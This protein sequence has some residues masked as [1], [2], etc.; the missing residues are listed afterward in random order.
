M[1]NLKE[2]F[3]ENLSLKKL[4]VF[5]IFEFILGAGILYFNY[6]FPLV[7][8]DMTFSMMAGAKLPAILRSALNQGN[9]RLLG[10]FLGYLVSFRLFTIIEKTFVWMGI[11][12][13]F[14]F[15]AGSKNLLFNSLTAII[16]IYPCD[17]IFSQVYAWNSGFQNY[18]VPVFVILFDL[19]LIKAFVK[20]R[21]KFT[22]AIILIL[23]FITAFGGQFF[24]ENSSLFAVCLAVFIVIASALNTTGKG[25]VCGIIYFVSVLSGFILMMTYP[26]ILGTSQKI[27]GYRSY[28]ASFSSL[29][30]TAAKNYRAVAN[31]FSGYFLLWIVLSASF[32]FLIS[33]VLSSY[34]G[35]RK[36]KYIFPAVKLVLIIYPVFSVFYG[37]VMKQTITFPRNYLKNAQCILLFVYALAVIF[38]SI[39]LIAGKKVEFKY[40]ISAMAVFSGVISAAPL[41][42]VSPIGARTFF[43][44]YICFLFAGLFSLK[45]LFENKIKLKENSLFCLSAAVLCCFTAVLGMALA[46]NKYCSSVRISYLKN[47]IEQGETSITLPLLPHENLVHEDDNI[48]AWSFYIK[49]TYDKTDIELDF[50]DW[51]TWYSDYYR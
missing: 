37:I 18:A 11:I 43:I 1:E 33:T 21:K 47:N 15:L 14:I 46:D 9:G 41:L 4:A 28:P 44:P 17:S 39:L 19:L 34:Y 32:I 20:A 31:D 25:V 38:T 16:L 30:S 23:L 42:A 8:D 27:S 45:Y 7:C 6:C 50:T 29:L 26:H 48:S 35:G 40:K 22:E 2:R 24:S 10:N 36:R 3:T 51:N 13:L 5:F 12:N 49:N